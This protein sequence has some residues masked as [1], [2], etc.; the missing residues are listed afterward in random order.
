MLN[1]EQGIMILKPIERA[2]LQTSFNGEFR[3]SLIGV[4]YSKILK[5]LKYLQ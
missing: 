1:I 5:K 3:N 2:L 4:Q